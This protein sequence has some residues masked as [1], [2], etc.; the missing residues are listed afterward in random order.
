MNGLV[1]AIAFDTLSP[2]YSANTNSIALLPAIFALEDTWIYVNT[3]NSSDEPSN[4]EPL[5]DER[6]GL[7]ATLSIPYVNPYNSHVRFQRDLYN[8][9][10]GG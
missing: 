7:R 4:V 2:L 1:W 3:T 9:W 10:L 5:I 8:S 6:F